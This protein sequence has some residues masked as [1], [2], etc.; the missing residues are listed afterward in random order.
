VRARSAAGFVVRAQDERNYYLL[1]I[2][3][4]GFPEAL[5]R[6]QLQAFVVRDGV[7]SPLKGSP[8]PL[9]E[10]LKKDVNNGEALQLL[11]Q[12]VGRRITARVCTKENFLEVGPAKFEDNDQFYPSGTVGWAALGP[13]RFQVASL[14]LVKRRPPAFE[15]K[16]CLPSE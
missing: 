13:E 15:E 10:Q 7:A 14:K 16:K 5:G 2:T 4:G 6:Y 12:F 1:R 11:I 8:V 3:G 9:S